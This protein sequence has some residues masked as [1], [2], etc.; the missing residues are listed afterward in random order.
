MLLLAAA[1]GFDVNVASSVLFPLIAVG[2][3][4]SFGYLALFFVTHLF[5]VFL[6]SLFSFFIVLAILGLMMVALPYRVFRRCSI[7]VRCG[8]VAVLM[9]VLSTSF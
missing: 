2:S 5:S 6:A 3:H 8:M 7:Y 9:A 4:S 1:L